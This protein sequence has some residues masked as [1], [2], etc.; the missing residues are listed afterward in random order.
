LR[1]LF[2]IARNSSFIY[3]GRAV[4]VKQVGRDL[5]VRYLLEGSVRKAGD[6]VRI[7]GQLIDT[8][9]ATHLWA[10]RF[11]GKL[12]NVFDLQDK[13]TASVVGAIAPKL[14]QAEIERAK[15]KPTEN[16]DAYD[17]F[18]RGMAAFYQW[19]KEGNDEAMALFYKATELDPKYAAAFGMAARCYGQRKTRGWMVDR[20][21][22]SAEAE[23]LARRAAE[24]GKD[25]AVALYSAGVILVWI[26]GD[27]A[28]GDALIDQALVLNP[29]LAWAWLYSGWVKVVLGEPA[30]A[31]EREERA[32][33]LSPHDPLTFIMQSA[34]AAAHFLL[35]RY[36]ESLAWAELSMRQQPNYLLSSATAAAAAAIAGNKAAA[37]RAMA[38]V[39]ETDPELRISNL[40]EHLSP[41]RTDDFSRFAE[42]MRLAGLPE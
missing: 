40:A 19:T 35:G 12:E 14:E 26:A 2:V 16:L 8:A 1:W 29:N 15:Q 33:R 41:I 32:M 36:Q 27:V 10:E 6:R 18:L 22:E 31:I 37:A 34:I 7:T 20:R 9:T 5:G 30:M 23:R 21:K 4:D 3:K 17:Y 25:D 28:T 24:L 38:R 42:A 13:I 11:D 39:R